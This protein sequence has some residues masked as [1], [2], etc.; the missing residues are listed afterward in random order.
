L[1]AVLYGTEQPIFR[2]LARFHYKK[3]IA[4]G[5]TRNPELEKRME[6][7]SAPGKP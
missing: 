4:G 3:A 2:E 5:V 7:D 1:L 6:N